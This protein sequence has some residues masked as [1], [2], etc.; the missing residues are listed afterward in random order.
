MIIYDI[1]RIP[2]ISNGFQWYLMAK[3]QLCGIKKE[4]VALRVH[5][6]GLF[7]FLFLYFKYMG[8]RETFCVCM[9][10]V[11]VVVYVYIFSNFR[12]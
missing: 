3:I 4:G 7:A 11:L 2:V 5:K 6:G 10:D 1:S 9:F 12:L 8:N